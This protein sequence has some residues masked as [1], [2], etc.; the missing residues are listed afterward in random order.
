MF[1][2]ILVRAR[3]SIS[4]KGKLITSHSQLLH[5]YITHY[6]L[7]DLLSLIA[8]LIN[9]INI[10]E[11]SYIRFI[12]YLK[13]ATFKRISNQIYVKVSGNPLLKYSFGFF[14]IAFFSIF[15]TFVYGSIYVT[16]DLYFY[17]QGGYYEQNGFLWL[18]SSP[19]LAYVNLY[20]EF[21][22]YVWFEYGLYMVM[23]MV[24]GCGYG[25]LSPRNP[26]SQLFYNIA[27]LTMT[28]LFFYYT[29][30]FIAIWL[31]LF[32]EDDNILEEYSNFLE[33]VNKKQ[34]K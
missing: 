32:E 26:P 25:D 7:Y 34:I 14:K 1:D 28:V 9:Q 23:Q 5:H 22:W 31:R 8:L 16:I 2:M 11:L 12:F 3:I 18:T 4:Q 24:R 15:F 30:K 17:F 29:S 6:L 13:L 20:N 33:N 27:S 19:R 10:A 21:D